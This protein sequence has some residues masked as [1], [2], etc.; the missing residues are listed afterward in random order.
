MTDRRN[1]P[2][3]PL[4]MA[5][6][7]HGALNRTIAFVARRSAPRA[8]QQSPSAF[9]SLAPAERAEVFDRLLIAHPELND[10]AERIARDLLAT[11]S[12]GQVASEVESALTWISL[13]ALAARAGRVRGRGYVHESEA[14][15]ELVDEAITPFR[16]DLDRRAALGLLDAAAS[17][18][19][20]IIAGVYRA[21]DPEE[22]TVLAYAGKDIPLEIAS[23]VL[24]HAEKL[25]VAIPTDA[26]D[27]SWP[28][29]TDLC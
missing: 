3:V 14:A 10:E 17:L 19:V 11:A 22:G 15:W 13:D 7:T 18:A 24:D 8:S 4:G 25:G 5:V 26:A 6:S 16:S 9:G 28:R 2:A 1:Q 27:S 23:D 29:W 12:V 21:R 20:G